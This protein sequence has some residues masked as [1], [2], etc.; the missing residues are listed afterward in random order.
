MVPGRLTS[1]PLHE[2]VHGG[3]WQTV[4]REGANIHMGFDLP[5]VLEQAE[6]TVEHVRAE[7]S[8]R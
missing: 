2:R 3:I 5:V 1:L 4:A 7:G 8:V 6:L